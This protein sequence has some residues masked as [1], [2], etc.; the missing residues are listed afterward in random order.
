MY[1]GYVFSV[2]CVS[3]LSKELLILI[4]KETEMRTRGKEILSQTQFKVKVKLV[5][6]WYKVG[7]YG[8]RLVDRN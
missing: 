1:Y 4:V 8:I 7:E 6:I 5:G 3:V 2:E